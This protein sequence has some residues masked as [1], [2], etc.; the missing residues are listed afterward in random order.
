MRISMGRLIFERSERVAEL[1]CGYQPP[2]WLARQLHFS[3]CDLRRMRHLDMA[4]PT[5]VQMRRSIDR[6]AAAVTVVREELT[7]LWAPEF[8]GADPNN[9]LTELEQHIG[10]LDDVAFIANQANS[11]ADLVTK[12]GVTKAGSGRARAAGSISAQT[13]CALLIL[14]TW[15]FV[16]GVEPLSKNR[17]AEETAE[18]YWRAAGG[19][20]H[21]A[22]E[23][24]LASW[25][26]HF[27]LAR[28]HKLN[29]TTAEYRR[30]LTENDRWWK[31]MNGLSEEA[32]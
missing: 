7:S 2:P 13:Y 29:A 9:P 6:L 31:L 17:R 22:G 20:A 23:D 28:E 12:T 15:E 21:S 19:P 8:L 26:R 10:W 14:V 11:S 4:R 16:H 3:I 32:A 25:R 24:P 1:I 5:R 30:H 27:K 18:A